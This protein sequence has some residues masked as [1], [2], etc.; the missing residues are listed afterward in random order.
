MF[1]AWQPISP[2]HLLGTNDMGYDIFTELVY[3]ARN[4]LV[5]GL[6]ASAISLVLGTAIGLWAGYVSGVTGEAVGGII[7]V[8]LLVPMLP[9][10]IVAASYLGAGIG[11]TAIVIALLGWCQTARAVRT[12]TAQ[13]KQT[14]FIESL[15]ILQIP[16]VR[17]VFRHILPNLM[18]TVLARY[19]LSV[20]SCMMMEAALSFIGLGDPSSVTWGG[21]VNF[22]YRNGGFARGALNWFLAPGLCIT[23]CSLSFRLLNSFFE[24]RASLVR[25]NAARSY[26]E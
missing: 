26:M 18:E 17:I 12:R 2:Y 13:L 16:K 15:V 1:R 22:A 24:Y 6:T 3:A 4:T 7:N 20:S 21:M 14:A 25:S 5:I 8:F 23:L 11:N 10:A 19:I 9:A